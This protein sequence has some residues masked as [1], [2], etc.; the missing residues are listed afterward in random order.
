MSVIIKPKVKSSKTK[1]TYESGAKAKAS[2]KKNGATREVVK[3]GGKGKDVY[4]TTKSGQE[5]VK[6]RISK[7]ASKATGL[8]RVTKNY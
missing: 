2:T 5:K 3:M 7:S 1:T 4:T 6:R 8:K